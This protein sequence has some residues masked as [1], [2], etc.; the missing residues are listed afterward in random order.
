MEPFETIQPG[1]EWNSNTYSNFL[2]K[3]TTE[4]GDCLGTFLPK[5]NDT[6]KVSNITDLSTSSLSDYVVGQKGCNTQQYSQM[7]GVSVLIPSI[8]LIKNDTNKDI[9]IYKIDKKGV[10][11]NPP[12]LLK[13]SKKLSITNIYN[14]TLFQ[15]TNLFGECLGLFLPDINK[16]HLVSQLSVL[17]TSSTNDYKTG[18]TGC[19]AQQ[20]SG[21]YGTS[22]HVSGSLIKN[23]TKNN[24]TIHWI[25]KEGKIEADGISLKPGEEWNA[26]TQSNYIYQIKNEQG[27]CIG[28]VLPKENQTE[29][30][31]KN[32][33]LQS[34]T[35]SDFILGTDGCNANQYSGMYGAKE[36]VAG[37]IIIND[38]NKP[39][40]IYSIDEQGKEHFTNKKSENSVYNEKSDNFEGFET[41]LPGELW[42]AS[43]FSNS[44]YRITDDNNKCLGTFVPKQGIIEKVST[45][46]GLPLDSNGG[47][48]EETPAGSNDQISVPEDNNVIIGEKSNNNI[49][50]LII[51][52]IFV[53]I[54]GYFSYSRNVSNN[55]P[56]NNMNISEI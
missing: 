43:T 8:E 19:G 3:L 9:Y 12:F 20:Q 32:T 37:K 28:T 13:P 40:R 34:A 30:V 5:D 14:N 47:A 53:V 46:T 41:I 4:A 54:V 33:S 50:Y 17:N 38:T 27:Q 49:L 15:I 1:E 48:S 16:L 10:R 18:M 44:L 55:I 42:S 35:L 52:I 39:I 11:I 22:K 31:S 6:M 24:I 36:E 26:S 23:D 56:P 29:L 7:Y 21:M 25:D 51:F 45:I 2:Y